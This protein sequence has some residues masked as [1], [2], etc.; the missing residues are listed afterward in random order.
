MTEQKRFIMSERLVEYFVVAGN[1][2]I[3]IKLKTPCGMFNVYYVTFATELIPP[4]Y[5][6]SLVLLLVLNQVIVNRYT[7]LYIVVRWTMVGLG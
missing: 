3:D 1:E 5:S 7:A 4:S 6:I 2:K